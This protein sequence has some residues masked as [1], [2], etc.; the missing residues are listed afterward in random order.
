MHASTK[1]S[2]YS[3][4][5]KHVYA[6]MHKVQIYIYTDTYSVPN[7]YGSMQKIGMSNEHGTVG[8]LHT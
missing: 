6:H 1:K 2:I 8:Q 5:E 4:R 7:K 3:N